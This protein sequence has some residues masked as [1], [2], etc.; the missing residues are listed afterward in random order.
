M[1]IITQMMI[2]LMLMFGV[3]TLA[4]RAVFHLRQRQLVK[5]LCFLMLVLVALFFSLMAFYFAYAGLKEVL[6]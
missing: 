5:A 3:L 2:G 6:G 4:P 1:R